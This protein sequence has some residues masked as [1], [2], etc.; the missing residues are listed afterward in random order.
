MSH[1]AGT[2]SDMNGYITLLFL[3]VLSKQWNKMKFRF[4]VSEKSVNSDRDF[5]P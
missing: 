5:I 4:A 2:E 3:K 1:R